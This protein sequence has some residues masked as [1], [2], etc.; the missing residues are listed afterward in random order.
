MRQFQTV[1]VLLS[2]LVAASLSAQEPADA[3]D[4]WVYEGGWLAR[5]AGGGW[6]EVN[7]ETHRLG[8]PWSFR[9]VRRT[10]EYVELRDDGRGVS[11]RLTEGELLAKFDG[12]GQA[13]EWKPLLKGRWK[14][15]G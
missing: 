3:R 13:G 15:R 11:V 2:L 9:E 7:E 6:Y 14:K 10:K 8:K 1:V 12:D 4:Y 5:Q